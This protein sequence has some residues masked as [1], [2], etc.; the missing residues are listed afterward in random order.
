MQETKEPVFTVKKAQ[1][2][3]GGSPH[4]PPSAGAVS[5]AL[6]CPT[7]QPH[8]LWLTRLLCPRDSPGKNTGGGGHSLLQGIFLTRGSNP[9]LLHY[10]QTLYHLSHQGSPSPLQQKITIPQA[11]HVICFKLLLHLRSLPKFTR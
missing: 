2:P 6:S 5:V 4:S 9:G 10:R 11:E 1:A 3:R 8:G 7:L